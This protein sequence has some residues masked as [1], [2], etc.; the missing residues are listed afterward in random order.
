MINKRNIKVLYGIMM[1]SS[2]WTKAHPSIELN[3]KHFP[4]QGGPLT[5]QFLR[6]GSTK[7]KLSFILRASRKLPWQCRELDN[8][9]QFFDNWNNQNKRTNQI[10]ALN[11]IRLQQKVKFSRNQETKILPQRTNISL[12]SKIIF[13]EL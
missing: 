11:V 6:K 5:Q 10:W 1:S 13:Q 2:L 8:P 12:Q 4:L 3:R 7:R 9:N